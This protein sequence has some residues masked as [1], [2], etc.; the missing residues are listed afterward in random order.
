MR[1]GKAR[2]KARSFSVRRPAFSLLSSLCPLC[3]CGSFPLRL[4]QLAALGYHSAAHHVRGG[5]GMFRSVLGF[6]ILSRTGCFNG[7]ALT[8]VNVKGPVEETVIVEPKGWMCRNKIAVI[9]VEG[10]L[11]NAHKS[12]LLSDGENPVSIFR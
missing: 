10:L 1:N 7:I 8:P 9:D 2:M 12:G 5:D 6:A 3:L 11:V 4:D